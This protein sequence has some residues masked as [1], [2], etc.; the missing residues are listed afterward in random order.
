[1]LSKNASVS[2]SSILGLNTT[3]WD[4]SQI[5]ENCEIGRNCTIG[6][7]VYIGPGVTIG[8]NCK[9]QNNSL[10][11]EP[12][13]IS[14]GV[15][16]GPGVVFTNDFYPRA[17][18]NDGSVK[19]ASDWS[20]VGV[21]V[22]RG[23]SIGAMAVCVAPVLIGEWA[24][25]GAGSVVTKD[26]PR[27]ALMVGVPAKQVGWVGRLGFSLQELKPGLWECKKSGDTYT[28]DGAGKLEPN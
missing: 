7:N 8:D 17:I 4:Y 24:L 22:E 27:F 11:Y 20:A 9:I 15:F 21:T 19:S 13:N 6:R 5:R 1:M 26:V 25:I 2:E 3:V 18:N 10:I 28:L 14:D 12:A 16:I 23:A